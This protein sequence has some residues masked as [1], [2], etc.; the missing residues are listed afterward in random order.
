VGIIIIKGL[1]FDIKKFA[2]DDGPGI[3]TTVFLKGCPMRCWWCHNPEGQA[4][5]TELM[6][7]YK[8]CIRC[9]ECVRLCPNQAFFSTRKKLGIN[10]RICSLCGLCAKKC[11]S[12][13]LKI[14]GREM[15]VE[16]V[17]KEI[18]KDSAFYEESGGGITLSGG[19]PLLQMNFTSAILGECK[20]RNIHTAVDTCGYASSKAIER[21]KDE[22]DLFLYD[23]KMM[24]DAEHRKYTGKSNKQILRNFE[25]LAKNG[26]DLLVRLPLIPGIND[27]KKNTQMTADFVLRQGVKRVCLLPYHKTGIEKYRG[28]GKRY[29]LNSIKIP[30]ERKL[31]VIKTQFEAF[32]LMVKIGG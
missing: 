24:D 19:E 6:Y 4:S 11:P 3:R 21:I 15:S 25:I 14:V 17:M 9:N 31:N 22:V 5:V 28:L 16:E 12:G 32:G 18:G 10:R 7:R 20:K 30:S 23:L 1:V 27:Y 8:K 13:A 2:V 29:N 26:N